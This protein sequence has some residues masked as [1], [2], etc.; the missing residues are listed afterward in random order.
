MNNFADIG[1]F[2]SNPAGTGFQS[3]DVILLKRQQ[4]PSGSQTL[5]FIV[6]R[7]PAFAGINP[8]N[9]LIERNTDDNIVAVQ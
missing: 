2:S 1:L 9:K 8:Y 6:S 7:K 4:L 5:E 3:S